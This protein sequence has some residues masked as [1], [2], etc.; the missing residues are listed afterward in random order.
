MTAQE[1]IAALDQALA[2][3]GE[4]VVLRRVVGVDPNTMNIDVVCRANVKT[5]RL[6]EEPLVGG[7][8]QAVVIVTMSPTQIAAAQWPGGQPPGQTID[9]SLP[10]RLDRIVIG[11]R[12]REIE[13]VDGITLGGQTVR[14]EMQVLG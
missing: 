8:A 11:G 14:I 10:R 3:N 4:D 12:E 5:W 7:I 6:K 1:C 13:A 2:E 9:P